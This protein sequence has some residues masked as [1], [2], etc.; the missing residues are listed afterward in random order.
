M[1]HL[2]TPALQHSACEDCKHHA[3][4]LLYRCGLR[5]TPRWRK[6]GGRLR[7]PHTISLLPLPSHSPELNPQENVWEFLRQNKL[8][9]CVFGGYLPGKERPG[10]IAASRTANVPAVLDS[11]S[12]RRPWQRAGRDEKMLSA[13]PKDRPK[14][15][16]TMQS[17]QVP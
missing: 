17:N 3:P 6:I 8:N 2:R 1:G 10:N 7:P 11:R 13:E 12:T 5:W 4:K 15:E 9:N 14:K 16:D